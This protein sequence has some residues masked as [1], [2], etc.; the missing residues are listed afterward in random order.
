MLIQRLSVFCSF[1]FLCAAV[2]V[3][4]TAP[5]LAKESTPQNT[6]ASTLSLKQIMADPDWIGHRVEQP[7]WRLD[8]SGDVVFSQKQDGGTLRDAFI[9]SAN[10]GAPKKMTDQQLVNRESPRQT[11]DASRNR[12]LEV[13]DGD[14]Y[15]HNL[16]TQRRVRLTHTPDAE[17]SPIFMA[18]G[19]HVAFNRDSTW[20][21]ANPS[22]GSER[23][24]ATIKAEEDPLNDPDDEAYLKQDQLRL[25]PTF[26]K[27]HEDAKAK[28]TRQKALAKTDASFSDAPIYLGEKQKV[29]RTAL[30]PSGKDVY[31]ITQAPGDDNGQKGHMPHYVTTSGYV[32]VEDVRTLVGKNPPKPQTLWHVN[33]NTHEM[34]KIDLD[35]LPGITQDPLASLRKKAGKDALKGNRGVTFGGVRFSDDGQVAAIMARAIDNKDRWIISLA[36][37]QTKAQTAHRLTDPAWINWNFNDFGFI[38]NSQT[39][40]YLSE[41][42]GYS[43]LYSKKL[44]KRGW[45]K[46]TQH[47]RGDFE[48]SAPKALADG[49]FFVI[50]NREAPHDYEL[51]HLPKSGKT[52]KPLTQL[53]GV[54]NFALSPDANKVLIEYS[55]SYLP[56]QIASVD[57]ASG[58]TTQHT[59]TRKPAF[60]NIAWQAPT[61]VTVPSKHGAKDI[62][63]KLYLPQTAKPE[64]GYPL[65]MFVHGAGYTQN[66]HQRYPYYFRE[67]M[68]HNLLTQKGYV[69]LDMDYRAS[70]GY[71]RDWRTAIYRQ[72]GHPE[73]E[74]HLD[75]I[76]WLVKHHGANRDRVGIY[77]GSYGG[78][79]TFMAMFR[80]P[81][82][83]KAGAALRPVTDWRMY[84]HGY[85]A[86]I[87]NTP[88]IDPEAHRKSS[89][90]EHAEGL[91]GHL[92]I[93]HGML[94]DNVFYQEAVRMAQRLIEL[95]K[96]HWE[97][98]SYPLERHGFT[99]PNAWLDEYRRILKLFDEHL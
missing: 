29:L 56:M 93:A 30:S 40:W 14:V 82:A 35:G 83:F 3:A 9:V 64:G 80:A 67:Q 86:N 54:E 98:A 52:L 16:S 60:K 94:D 77:G 71:G 63:A 96:E 79:M 72:M 17:T 2:C 47:T 34:A 84:N 38:P 74:D 13:R 89:P 15:F 99:E 53:N 85:T 57:L 43:H 59:D 66:V 69:V 10:G 45:G 31:V 19:T 23:P 58:Q 11:F 50:A 7:A 37:Q 70:E 92:L 6:V 51:Y 76:D 65:V 44:G 8:G 5:V 95:E 33:L 73:L 90:I 18:D 26:A 25:F 28:R 36:S 62:H 4:A 97:L 88:D 55:G 42:S 75:G 78:F 81:E 48:I 41:E 87:L 24:V 32:D 12:V 21:I 22:T 46:A 49:S 27:R 20:W 91:Q 1:G 39:L 61:F 68:F